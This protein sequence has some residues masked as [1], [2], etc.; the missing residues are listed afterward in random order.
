MTVVL[1]GR[2]RTAKTGWRVLRELENP[3]R[4]GVVSLV[5]CT[6]HTGR[7][8]QIRVHLKHLGYPLLG[9]EVYGKRGA[10]SRQMLH[11]WKLGFNHPLTAQS[12]HFTAPVPADARPASLSI[13]SVP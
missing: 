12:L 6:L 10:Y 4:P 2:G 5:E 3:G 1:E 11:A 13:L 7:T 9:D 8:H